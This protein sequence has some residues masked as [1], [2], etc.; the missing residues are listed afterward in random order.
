[1][2]RSLPPHP[3]RL[4]PSRLV[5]AWLLIAAAATGAMWEV[6]RLTH[7]HPP[8]APPHP[9][10]GHAL[11]VIGL[12]GGLI[13]L[14]TALTAVVAVRER[15]ASMLAVVQHLTADL[16]HQA[17]HDP[18]TGLANR[19]LL[20]ERAEQALTRA[21]RGDATIAALYLDLDGFKAI[22]DTLGHAAGDRLLREV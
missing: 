16:A 5:V 6:L 3:G 20:D 19:A 22:N 8:V 18:L 7:H 10:P 9:P 4:L 14:A 11:A 13:V 12:M 21:R 1:M 15:D 2:D 17:F